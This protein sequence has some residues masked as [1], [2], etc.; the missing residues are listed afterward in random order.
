MCPGQKHEREGGLQV[1][2][3][4]HRQTNEPFSLDTDKVSCTCRYDTALLTLNVINYY[5]VISAQNVST[6]I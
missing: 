5:P 4:F 1:T 3:H 2:S 6:D